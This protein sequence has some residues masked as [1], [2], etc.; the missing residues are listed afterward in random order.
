MN[1]ADIF[2]N[3]N[4][5]IIVTDCKQYLYFVLVNLFSVLFFMFTIIHLFI[6]KLNEK[7]CFLHYLEINI[8]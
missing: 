4:F 2:G 5:I 6:T 3:I 1:M 8:F 7:I